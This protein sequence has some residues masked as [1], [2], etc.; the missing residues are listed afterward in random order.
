MPDVSINK[1]VYFPD[2]SIN[3]L[4]YF[5]TKHLE[6]K[7][8]KSNI[9]LCEWYPNER[10]FA[11]ELLPRQSILFECTENHLMFIILINVVFS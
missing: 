3:K 9:F 5:L 1:L 7:L 8:D 6:L 2:V 4:M 10:V 11:H